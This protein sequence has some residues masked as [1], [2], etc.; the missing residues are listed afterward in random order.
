MKLNRYAIL[1]SAVCAFLA[2][3]FSLAAP[4]AAPAQS[5][6]ALFQQGN[7][8]YGQGKYQEALHVYS[9]II[10]EDGFSGPLLSNLANCY[11]QIGRA[12]LAVLNYERALRLAP[13][14]SDSRGNL[15]LLRK[16]QGL[17]QEEL[18]L[19]R[20]AASFLDLDQWTLLAGVF[21][22]LLTL[23]NLAGLRFSN[24]KQVRRWLGGL[25]LV[26]LLVASAGVVSQYRQ[27]DEAVVISN[28][29]HLLLSPFPTSSSV[30]V[31]AEGRIVF[32]LK[33]HGLYSLVEDHAGR[34]G[35]LETAAITSIDSIAADLNDHPDKKGSVK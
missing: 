33:Q 14:D 9:R 4:T 3:F 15:D 24:G 25:C 8:L 6:K 29:A 23:I 30:G 19:A 26:V 16:T 1:R 35:W 13:G 2:L 27:L 21:L 17:F 5:A 31:V 20:R 12:G 32:T 34:T 28:D 22:V 11:A 10:A 18:P 7:D